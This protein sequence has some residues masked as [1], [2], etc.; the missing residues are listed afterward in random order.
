LL[1]RE[2]RDAVFGIDRECR[3]LRNLLCRRR[4]AVITSITPVRAGSKQNLREMFWR[5]G[6]AF[7]RG[8]SPKS[9]NMDVCKPLRKVEKEGKRQRHRRARGG[10]TS[11]ARS[12]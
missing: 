1:G 4:S 6:S 12:S 7:T 11:S 2:S 5:A 10:A 3:H 9:I 8:F